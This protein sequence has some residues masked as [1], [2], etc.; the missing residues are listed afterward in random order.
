[1]LKNCVKNY[2]LNLKYFFTP[3]G[4]L[5]IGAVIGLSVFIPGS[6]HTLSEFL[7]TVEEISGAAELDFQKVIEKAVETVAALD[8]TGDPVAA[9]STMLSVEWLNSFMQSCLEVISAQLAPY[10]QEI[11]AAWAAASGE[12]AAY[13]AVFAVFTAVGLTGGFALTRFL[14]RRNIA[15]RAFWKVFLSGAVDFLLAFAL[16]TFSV[17]LSALWK[18]GGFIWAFAS[19]FLYALGSLCSAFIVHGK[20]NVNPRKIISFKN[21]ALLL[22][23]NLIVMAFSVLFTV[24]ATLFTNV[25]AGLFIGFSFIEIALLVMSLNAEAFVKDI[26]E[27]VDETY[28]LQ[29]V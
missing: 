21:A 22:L 15:R 16:I 25:F 19:V 28:L 2:F 5:A 23:G 10:S 14:I 9:L 3:I 8:W 20:K 7:K 13:F 1:M 24:L 26:V 12:I 29:S 27:K 18:P 4:A 11:S 17:W 6:L